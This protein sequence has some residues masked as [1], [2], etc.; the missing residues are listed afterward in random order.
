MRAVSPQLAGGSSAEVSPAEVTKY[1]DI[2]RD[3]DAE[4]TQMKEKMNGILKEM[5]ELKTGKEQLAAKVQQLHDENTG[6]GGL[7]FLLFIFQFAQVRALLFLL[8]I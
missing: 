6:E 8:F 2:I 1:K 4:L 7:F 3:Q 5:E